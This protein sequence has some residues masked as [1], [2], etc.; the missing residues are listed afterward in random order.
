MKIDD[1]LK[2]VVKLGASDLHITV[3]VPCTVRVHG[4]LQFLDDRVLTP[5]D[6][7]NLVKE[8]T[9]N[10]W[11]KL[12]KKVE[13]DFSYSI[14]GFQRLRVSAYRQRNTFSAAS[15]SLIQE[16]PTLRVGLPPVV[17]KLA[18]QKRA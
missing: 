8:L 17:R 5:E 15:G 18:R 9:G 12:T 14:P 16:S 11:D 10:L 2:Q 4:K 1:L 6:T 3:G 13:I 7:K